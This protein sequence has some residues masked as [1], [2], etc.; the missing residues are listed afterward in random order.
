MKQKT[1]FY[2]IRKVR[3]CSGHGQNYS[4]YRLA[5]PCTGVLSDG[6]IYAVYLV[7]LYCDYF[8]PYVSISDSYGSCYM[9]PMGIPPNQRSGFG[10]VRC[11]GLTPPQM[12]RKK[13]LRY[14]VPDLVIS[15]TRGIQC[16]D[17]EGNAVTIFI[18]VLGYIG[19][20]P[21]IS[22]ALDV[23]GHTA[24]APCHLCSFLRKDRTGEAGRNY[25]GYTSSGHGRSASLVRS[26]DR[27]LSARSSKARDIDLSELG[28]KPD[29]DITNY[30]LHFLSQQLGCTETEFPSQTVGRGLCQGSSNRTGHPL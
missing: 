10:A 3:R 12:S 29:F 8:Q 6:R 16:L 5:A 19:D 17:P 24:R 25:Y 22:H 26:M 4:E 27:M 30:P 15:A 28:F 14:I 18:D 20:Y 13:I 23:L 1:T 9:L 11:L 7:L 2:H 21:G